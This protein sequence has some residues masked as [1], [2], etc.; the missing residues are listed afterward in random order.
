M[1]IAVCSL[2]INNWYRDIVKYGK[3]TLKNYC[4][5]YGYDFIYETEKTNDTVYD[6]KRDA[7]WYKIQLLLKVLSNPEYDF[8]IW[9]DADSMIV[10]DDK[11]LEHFIEKYLGDKDI[12]VA[13]D[14][15]SILNTGTMFIKNSDFSKKILQLTWDNTHE[16]NTTLHE[17]AS[18]GDLY[19]RNVIG[20]K[21]HIVVLAH[22]L[23][24]EFLTYW[25]S[26]YPTG[27][28]IVHITRCAHDRP[29][30]IF[31]MDLFCPIKMDE[32]SQEQYEKRRK[33]LTTQ[34]I[35]RADIDHYKNGGQRR[36]SSARYIFYQHAGHLPNS[37]HIF[38]DSF[39]P[40]LTAKKASPTVS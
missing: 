38:K 4:E 1:K 17:Q 9:N 22:H 35:C 14:W 34:E 18:L 27:C 8:V 37:E 11:N 40:V 21:D 19:T 33:W 24:N 30:F 23:Q 32:E 13:R 15:Q 29:G 5:K 6:G 20:C 26:Y 39:C 31:T 25:Y 12:L 7:P 28:F 2:Y 16:F 10:S 36:N 3:I